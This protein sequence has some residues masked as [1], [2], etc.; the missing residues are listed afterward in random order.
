MRVLVS[1]AI[2][3]FFFGALLV[4]TWQ[5][6]PRSGVVALLPT[7]SSHGTNNTAP[8]QTIRDHYQAV[9][10]RSDLLASMTLREKVGQLFMIGH[11]DQ[12]EFYHTANMLRANHFGGVIIMDV[13]PKNSDF[14]SVWSREW[15]E[16]S[17]V[18]PTLV[19]IDQEGGPVTRL[20]GP[21]YDATGQRELESVA[22]AAALGTAR[23]NELA[24]LG[25]NLN[26]APVLDTSISSSSFLFDRTFAD[27]TSQA[28]LAD[29]LIAT[30]REL[31]V[32][33]AIKHYPGHPDTP[34]DSHF[35]LPIIDIPATDFA[36][37]THPFTE[38]IR[39][40]QPA[41]V[42]TAHVLLPNIDPSYPATLSKE[43]LTNQLRNQVGFEGI[44]MTD[45]L[46][47]GAIT[48]NWETDDAAVQA[49]KAG[50]DMILFA[51]EPNASIAARDAVIT[52]VERGE[53]S[54]DRINTSVERI[55]KIKQQIY[56]P[57]LLAP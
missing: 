10:Q 44:I 18:L 40:S 14:V 21:E 49:I 46:T 43:I 3:C 47:M 4:T 48:Q 28:T 42:M 35:V 33:S 57:N 8:L 11:W 37:F 51:A 34:E 15:Q 22:A 19:A 7:A 24:T 20:R 12:N 50:A 38:V 30:Q 29:A 27:P 32:L 45:D 56:G 2:W 39:S 36:N 25:I 41:V 5:F 31:G 23:G 52:A 53:I 16:D 1:T 6:L 26:L 55:L 13:S 17:V 54:L 9:D